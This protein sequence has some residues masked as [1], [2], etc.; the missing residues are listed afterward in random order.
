MGNYLARRRVHGV[1]LSP[2]P[3][4]LALLLT[5]SL[6]V[7]AALSPEG[8]LAAEELALEERAKALDQQLICPVCP[9]ETLHQSQVDLAKQMRQIIRER[10][11]ADQ[12]EQEILDYFVSVYGE[13]VLA[14]PAKRGFSLVA[15]LV[16][17]LA[18]LAGSAAVLLAIRSLKKQRAQKPTLTMAA[19][20]EELGGYLEIVDREL[21]A[22]EQG[23]RGG[24]T[25]RD[26]R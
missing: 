16:P 20:G 25:R 21:R 8:A 3:L 5:L 19:T 18:I 6:M 1:G 24:Q 7:L 9:G 15:W 2:R 26:A 12:S 23:P 17:P 13:S 14:A 22:R 11:A 4:G 10:L